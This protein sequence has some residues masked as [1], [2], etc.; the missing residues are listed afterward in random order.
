MG[1]KVHIQESISKRTVR[2]C[3][4]CLARIP[5]RILENTMSKVWSMSCSADWKVDL[6]KS[7]GTNLS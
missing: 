6:Y 5:S 2:G 1:S 4:R 3:L 7:L